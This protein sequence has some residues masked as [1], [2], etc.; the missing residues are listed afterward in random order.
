MGSIK[1]L[2]PFLQI[3]FAICL[4]LV[5][6]LPPA[7]FLYKEFE[8]QHNFTYEAPKRWQVIEGEINTY[9]GCAYKLFGKYIAYC[10][11]GTKKQA[12]EME[13]DTV[14]L[15]KAINVRKSLLSEV[16][17]I[18]N[19]PLDSEACFEVDNYFEG[20]PDKKFN[21]ETRLF[22]H[23]S[24]VNKL[25]DISEDD[26][27]ITTLSDKKCV[28]AMSGMVLFALGP[29]KAQVFDVDFYDGLLSSGRF[30]FMKPESDII[31]YSFSG[32]QL[33]ING[34]KAGG[35]LEAIREGEFTYFANFYEDTVDFNIVTKLKVTA[36][37]TILQ[38]II[39]IISV[40]SIWLF[41]IK[42]LIV[43]GKYLACLIYSLAFKGIIK[44]VAMIKKLW[45]FIIFVLRRMK[46]AWYSV[47]KHTR[48]FFRKIAKR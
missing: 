7:A 11:D 41:L 48:R 19:I 23:K 43:N 13:L 3:L 26:T 34:V 18:S 24:P 47:I 44:I 10:T 17:N 8:P 15:D 45:I 42:S 2:W 32:D 39:L 31:N 5:A 33:L 35:R 6:F 20:R 16:F 40:Y 46:R 14:L 38:K 4:L 9:P 25:E 12:K 36:R 21:T 22:I 28:R 27:I 37:P 29:G 30:S 1:I